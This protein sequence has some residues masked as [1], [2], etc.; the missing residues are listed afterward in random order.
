MT[1]LLETW[2]IAAR[3]GCFVPAAIEPAGLAIRPN[4]RAWSVGQ[5]F[6]H[7]H[8][9]RCNWLDAR[10]AFRGQ[11]AMEGLPFQTG[12]WDWSRR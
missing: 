7:L 4:A 11:V 3:V 1:E 8:N 9:K 10:A 2:D 5:H 12:Q 6:V